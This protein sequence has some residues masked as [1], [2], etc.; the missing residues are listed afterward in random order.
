MF[1][2]I[3]LLSVQFLASLVYLVKYSY[4]VGIARKNCMWWFR[5]Q[6]LALGF[7]VNI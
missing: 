2:E 4:S 3:S 7:P 5:Q 1:C 6:G